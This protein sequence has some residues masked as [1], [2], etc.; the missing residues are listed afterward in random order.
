MLLLRALT[1]CIF[2]ACALSIFLY[3]G[4]EFTHAIFDLMRNKIKF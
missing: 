4:I 3:Q 2:S 1:I